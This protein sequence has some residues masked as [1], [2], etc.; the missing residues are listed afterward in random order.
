MKKPRCRNET[1]MQR[2]FYF[3]LSFSQKLLFQIKSHSE[4]ISLRRISILVS[5][6]NCEGL[7]LFSLP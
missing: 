4:K 6:I 1:F 7:N 3:F 2:G 5:I